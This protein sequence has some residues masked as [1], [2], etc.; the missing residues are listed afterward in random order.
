MLEQG[1]TGCSL[2]RL[3]RMS[4]Q[5][6]FARML[7]HAFLAGDLSVEAITDRSGDML[8]RSWRWLR[9]L[10][11]RFARQFG[12]IRPRHRDVVR[13][14][15][16]DE[17]FREAWTKHRDE[18]SV[19][20][21]LTEPQAMRPVAAA[22]S[23]QLPA[24]ESVGALAK[25][26]NLSVSELE[27][28]ADLKGLAYRSYDSPLSHY[29]Y[30]I[31]TKKSGKIRLLEAPKTRL[32]KLQQQILSQILHRIPPHPAS[33]GFVHGRSIRTFISPHVKQRVVLRMD[34]SDFFPS[35]RA[36]RIQT[37]FRML[38]YPE[39][40]ADLLG[41]IGTTATA[42]HVWKERPIEVN[43]DDWRHAREL[44]SRPHLPQGAPTSPSLANIC[45]Y[46]VD[47]R[48]SGL[49]EAAAVEY[50]RYADDIA[51]S[52]DRDFEKHVERF[53]THAAAVLL[54]EGFVV[55]FRKT[56][57]M[58][59]GVRQQLVG[60][61][62]NQRMNVMRA[63]FDRLK[64]TLTN[65]VRHGP[66]SQNRDAH[67]EFRSHLEGRLAFVESINT[68]KGVRL[69]RIFEQIRWEQ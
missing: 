8:G 16:Q 3:S 64:A 46:R 39:P 68:Q 13:F 47:C 21:W 22:A 30:R 23:W 34:L 38:G 19:E 40:V 27:W 18:L 57:I 7:A 58:R 10:A 41:G 2:C 54:E 20:Q 45:C 36:A 32:K 42:A 28:F 53:A 26:L 63:D 51:F 4:S 49:A 43:S 65:C 17:G 24:L 5:R 1:E 60:L 14:V 50:T 67:P 31:L 25:W 55:N 48:L 69:R 44:Y 62:A 37:V 9:P 33:H 29:S 35:F 52:G 61:V 59:Q 15:Q 66:A 56:R 12:P 6:L 11:K